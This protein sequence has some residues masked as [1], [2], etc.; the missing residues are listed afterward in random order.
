MMSTLGRGSEF[1]LTVR[2][3]KSESAKIL[4]DV[5]ALMDKLNMTPA[6]TTSDVENEEPVE[7]VNLLEED[8]LSLPEPLFIHEK[9]VHTQLPSTHDLRGLNVLIV[10]DNPA[11]QD[12]I[13]LFLGP[14]GCQIQSVLNGKEALEVLNT[15]PI[16]VVIMDIRMPEMDGIE[17]THA[18]RKS[19]HNYNNIPIIAL[20]ADASAQT[21]AACMA[22]GADIFLT[23]P[24]MARSIFLPI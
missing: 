12:V 16:D 11:N 8:P 10:E 21:N 24:I 19:N 5:E 22:A 13:K 7:T 14:E 23:K 15:Q 17:T 6:L 9:P 4:D 3:K 20:T 1:V 2:G 18:I